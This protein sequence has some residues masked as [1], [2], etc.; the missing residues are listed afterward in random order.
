MKKLFLIFFV[1]GIFLSATAQSALDSLLPVRGLTVAAPRPAVL[2]DFVKFIDSEL[3]PAH[4]NM[5]ILRVEYNYAYQKHPEL[6]DSLHLTKADIKKLVKVCRKHNI[7]LIP[8]FDLLGHQS[9]R[10]RLGNLL[11]QYPE[12]DETPNIPLLANAQAPNP[13]GLIMKSYCPRHPDV[14][15]VVF[16]IIDELL[17]VFETDYF[18]AGMDEVF[19]I[20][21][22]QCPR[23]KGVDKA[24]LFAEEVRNIHSHLK[25]RNSQM[26]IWGDRLIDGRSTG[27]GMWEGSMNNTHRAIDKI[28]KDVFICDWHYE[29]PDLTP[30]LMAAKGFDV[31]ICPWRKGDVA[32]TQ[33]NNM[34]R[35]REHAAPVM[36]QHFQG[37]IQTVWHSAEMLLREYWDPNANLEAETATACLKRVMR[38]LRTL[39]EGL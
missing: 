33:L 10:Y 32:V 13:D 8:L 1:T 14:H 39:A 25:Q 24:E 7:Q 29:R 22:D 6:R 31:A 9:S 36:A 16:N 15:R 23:C 19:F 35:Y 34:I 4:F 38:E 2:D 26:M 20:G 17:D 28:P 37:I 30:V 12:F 5:L 11:R 3:A 27:T 18:H 21:H